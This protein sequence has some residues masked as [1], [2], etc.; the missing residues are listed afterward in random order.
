MNISK[1]VDLL[2][3][4]QAQHGDLLVQVI[5]D[6]DG[7]DVAYLRIFQAGENAGIE[8]TAYPKRVLI[9]YGDPEYAGNG[10]EYGNPH[11]EE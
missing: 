4:V 8:R 6:S 10:I 11:E 7:S 9:E 1:L 5:Y 2:Q 3:Q